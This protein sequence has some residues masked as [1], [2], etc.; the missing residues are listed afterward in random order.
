MERLTKLRRRA[1]AVA[2]PLG[3]LVFPRLRADAQQTVAA[4]DGE[5]RLL[6]VADPR[7]SELVLRDEIEARLRGAVAVHLVVPVCVSP[8]HF[9]TDD[10]NDERRDSTESLLLSVRLLQQHGVPTTGSLGGDD[11]LEAMTDAL[12]RFPATR[13]LLA[14]PPDDENYSLERRL[15]E[16][17]RALTSIPVTQIVVPSAREQGERGESAAAAVTG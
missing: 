17:E 4:A 13:V 2:I 1:A 5:Q 15:L 8:L 12:R 6:V 11:P 3:R 16:N 7:C 9:L 10:E 14:V